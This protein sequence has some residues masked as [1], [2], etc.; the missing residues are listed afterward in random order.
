MNDIPANDHGQTTAMQQSRWAH[1]LRYVP[2]DR[3]II[4]KLRESPVTF[5]ACLGIMCAGIVLSIV[6]PTCGGQW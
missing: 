6:I 2:R 4:D 1:S 3:S 5:C